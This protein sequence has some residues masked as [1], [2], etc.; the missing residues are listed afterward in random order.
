MVDIVDDKPS[1]KDDVSSI[2]K[3]ITSPNSKNVITVNKSLVKD[4]IILNEDKNKVESLNHKIVIAPI[5][6]DLH[7][8]EINK[9]ENIDNSE[10]SKPTEIAKPLETTSLPNNDNLSKDLNSVSSKEP[11]SEDISEENK[12][13]NEIEAKKTLSKK[14]ESLI[15]SKKYFLPINVIAKK[16][17]KKFVIISLILI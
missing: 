11:E 15:E 6:D 2:N 12:K 17:T 14:Y 10:D 5:S 7:I 1:L 9:V 3:K 4:N 16:K 13:K 8:D